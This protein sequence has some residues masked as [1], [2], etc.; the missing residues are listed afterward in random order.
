MDSN[1]QYETQS[2]TAV[3]DLFMKFAFIES[4]GITAL[5]FQIS[6]YHNLN[7]EKHNKFVGRLI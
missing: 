6:K 2:G 1:N 4:D 7:S 5:C 3:P